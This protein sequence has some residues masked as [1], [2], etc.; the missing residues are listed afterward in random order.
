MADAEHKTGRIYDGGLEMTVRHFRSK[1]S[2]TSS[3]GMVL[4]YVLTVTARVW[5]LGCQERKLSNKG[6][7]ISLLVWKDHNLVSKLS[8]QSCRVQAEC[9]GSECQSVGRTDAGVKDTA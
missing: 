9:W 8:C 4:L 3:V 5:T 7:G 6:R 2:I 1:F